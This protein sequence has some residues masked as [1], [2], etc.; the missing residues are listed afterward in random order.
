MRKPT[1]CDR[2]LIRLI[3][4]EGLTQVE[5][6]RRMG[7]TKQAVNQRLKEL[8]GQQ[9]KVVAIAK[10]EEGVNA[11]FDAMQQLTDIN[12][13]SLELLDKAEHNP[14]LCLKCIGEVRQQIKLASDIYERMFNIK[15][16]HEFMETV[17]E[18]LKK[19]DPSVYQEFKRKINSNR[20]VSG[21][22]RF[23]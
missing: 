18:T 3:D 15:V 19:V 4:R 11:G 20:S 14:E 10:I 7:V 16:V 5:A 12:N 2:T 17:A 13:R 6:G 8:R 23:S 1:I 22:I 21:A 9:T